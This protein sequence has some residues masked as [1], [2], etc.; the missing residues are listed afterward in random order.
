MGVIIESP[1]MAE[2]TCMDIEAALDLKTY[3]VVL[4][5]Q[6]K[7]RWI[8]R[9]GAEPVTYDK[10]PDTGFWRRFSVGFMRILPV[11]GQL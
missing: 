2:K 5:E 6:G 3:E 11:K 1:E 10:E 7:L 9:S 8:D 4:N